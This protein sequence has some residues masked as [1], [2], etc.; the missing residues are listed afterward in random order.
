MDTLIAILGLCIAALAVLGLAAVRWGGR[1]NAWLRKQER[2][3]TRR[4]RDSV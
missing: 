1:A 4:Y 3:A 2:R